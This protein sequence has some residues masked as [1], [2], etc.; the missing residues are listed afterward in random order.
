MNKLDEE[1]EFCERDSRYS[2]SLREYMM[3]LNRAVCLFY[4]EYEVPWVHDKY[5]T[6]TGPWRL[7]MCENKHDA[8]H[9]RLSQEVH[10]RLSAVVGGYKFVRRSVFSPYFNFIHFEVVIDRASGRVVAQDDFAVIQRSTVSPDRRH[11]AV[12]VPHP[13]YQFDDGKK[14]RGQLE[15]WM[16]ELEVQGYEVAVVNSH[17]WN[18]M[19][20][21]T[22]DKEQYFSTK[23]AAML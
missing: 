21:T 18:S 19:K 11:L 13:H 1:L 23:I 22:D 15:L 6:D 12:L 7:R 17:L 10:D 4:P 14:R 3:E 16:E 8:E 20:M 9:T 5:C 2:Q